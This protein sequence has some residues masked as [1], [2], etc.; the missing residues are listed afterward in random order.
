MADYREEDN[1]SKEQYI[2]DW[3]N[4]Q[5]YVLFHRLIKQVTLK[6]NNL[7]YN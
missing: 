7:I 4:G 6:K 2:F 3:L 1:Q 5:S